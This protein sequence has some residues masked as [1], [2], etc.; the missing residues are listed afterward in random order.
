MM[1]GTTGSISNWGTS[2]SAASVLTWVQSWGCGNDG[3]H[4]VF[5]FCHASDDTMCYDNG[6]S[7]GFPRGGTLFPIDSR[8]DDGYSYI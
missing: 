7:G 5:P 1:L 6:E 8:L 3:I 4:G 2:R